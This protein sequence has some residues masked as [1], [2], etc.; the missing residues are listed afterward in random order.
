MKVRAMPRSTPLRT[1]FVTLI[2]PMLYGYPEIHINNLSCL[3]I[4]YEWDDWNESFHAHA[5]DAEGILVS[6]LFLE[7]DR[8]L[9]LSDEELE[10]ECALY[11]LTSKQRRY[12]YGDEE[13]RQRSLL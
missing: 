5:Y 3:K 2:N 11:A 12:N 1:H 9:I 4:Y 6:G 13:E 7:G 8:F 10:A